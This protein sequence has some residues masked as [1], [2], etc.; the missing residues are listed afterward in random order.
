MG[1]IKDKGEQEQFDLIVTGSSSF[2]IM[3]IIVENDY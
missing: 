3:K 1:E 2:K